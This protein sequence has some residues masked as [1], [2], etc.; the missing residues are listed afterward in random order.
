[1]HDRHTTKTVELLFP[2]LCD[3]TIGGVYCAIGQIDR[4]ATGGDQP[5]QPC[6]RRQL[7]VTYGF[8]G[9]T[10]GRQQQHFPLIIRQVETAHIH[11]HGLADRLNDQVNLINRCISRRHG[12]DDTR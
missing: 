8:C 11:R 1:M 4:M 12:L 2:C 7:D 9:Q 6:A 5:H 10:V 3:I